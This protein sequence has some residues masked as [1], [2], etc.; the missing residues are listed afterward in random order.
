MV[1]EEHGGERQLVRFR[2]W[3]RWRPALAAA[4]AIPVAPGATA[5]VCGFA[6]PAAILL[7]IGVVLFLLA[8]QDAALAVGAA[9]RAVVAPRAPAAAERREP[10]RAPAAPAHEPAAGR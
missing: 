1:I 6:A 10:F 4:V 5:L 9:A 3:P 8:L 2:I 7:A